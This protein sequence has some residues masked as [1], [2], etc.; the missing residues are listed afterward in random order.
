MPPPPPHAM[1]TILIPSEMKHAATSLLTASG[2]KDGEL[3]LTCASATPTHAPMETPLQAKSSNITPRR[4]KTSTRLHDS[5]VV[6]TSPLLST[7]LMEWPRRTREQPSNALHGYSRRSGAA[8][9]WT[10][11]TSFI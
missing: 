9:I 10:W 11:Q 1:P 4:R 7:L 8:H 2:T 3:S 6:E 5:T